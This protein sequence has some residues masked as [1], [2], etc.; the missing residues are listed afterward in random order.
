MVTHSIRAYNIK[1]T[2]E[3]VVLRKLPSDSGIRLWRHTWNTA[4]SGASAW[5]TCGI[6]TD[7]QVPR[8]VNTAMKMVAGGLWAVSVLKLTMIKYDLESWWRLRDWGCFV[9]MFYQPVGAVPYRPKHELVQSSTAMLADLTTF[10]LHIMAFAYAVSS[11]LK[12]KFP[13]L[14]TNCVIGKA[15]HQMASQFGIT[16]VSHNTSVTVNVCQREKKQLKYYIMKYNR[17][18]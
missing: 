16:T 15:V 1:R 17:A 7:W 3:F 9:A 6:P 18:A 4:W 10:A 8:S 2:S 12:I 14:P 11:H 13:S 5:S